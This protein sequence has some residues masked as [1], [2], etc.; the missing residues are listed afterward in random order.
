MSEESRIGT[1]PHC[2]SRCL[3]GA[4][5]AIYAE[6]LVR[7]RTAQTEPLPRHRHCR[8]HPPDG[9]PARNSSPQTESHLS[10]GRQEVGIH[11]SCRMHA[12]SLRIRVHDSPKSLVPIS[13]RPGEPSFLNMRRQ[14][15]SADPACPACPACPTS[16]HGGSA[17]ASAFRLAPARHTPSVCWGVLE[18][19]VGRAM[20]D[21]VASLQ[22]L[23]A[24]FS[25]SLLSLALPLPPAFFNCLVPCAL[26][27]C[28]FLCPCPVMLLCL[29]LLPFASRLPL[30]RRSFCLCLCFVVPRPL[31]IES[32]GSTP[33]F[34]DV[35][36]E[37]T[38]MCRR[39]REVRRCKEGAWRGVD[40]RGAPASARLCSRLAGGRVGQRAEGWKGVRGRL[41][42]RG[43]GTSQARSAIFP[44]V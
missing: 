3:G 14:A 20:V 21:G 44:G 29:C 17:L 27:L 25:A 30:L 40:D 34:A 10:V 31:R 7:C 6:S 24:Q 26:A 32:P 37:L 23:H 39:G 36:A 9:G 2:G 18:A 41:G 11:D 28:L 1:S 33:L 22:A 5:N 8:L 13:S 42:G 12:R 16:R 38:S 4:R 35:L 43:R 19:L 15:P